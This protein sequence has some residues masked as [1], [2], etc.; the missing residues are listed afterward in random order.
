MPDDLPHLVV[1][2]ENLCGV[3]WLF[4]KGGN[5]REGAKDHLHHIHAVIS[6]ADDWMALDEATILERVMQD[7]HRAL[8]GS[9]GIVPVRGRAV[10]EKRAT[11]AATPEVEQFRP[12]AEPGT[13]GLH[14][15]GIMNLYLA[16]DWTD[17]GWPATMEG[18]VRSGYAAAAAIAGAH[19]AERGEVAGGQI[20]DIPPGRIAA[21]L[22]LR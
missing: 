20:E 13:I 10:K 7:I 9:S 6:A 3:Q 8:P 21:L 4:N 1:V 19:D 16:G 15:G 22:G 2:G 12:S 17:T 11:F 18:A 5:R 14:G